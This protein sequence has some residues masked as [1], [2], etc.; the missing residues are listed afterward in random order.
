MRNGPFRRPGLARLIR[1]LAQQI[2][3]GIRERHNPLDPVSRLRRIGG[4]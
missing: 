1:F 4:L 3:F 2:F